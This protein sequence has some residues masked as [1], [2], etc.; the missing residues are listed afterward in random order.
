MMEIGNI[1][2]PWEA[3]FVAMKSVEKVLRASA[4]AHLRS[5]L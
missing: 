4:I 5:A 1:A 3:H 2:L